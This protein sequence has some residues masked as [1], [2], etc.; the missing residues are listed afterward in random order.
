MDSL[1]NYAVVLI[2]HGSR[3]N[4]Y[5]EDIERMARS[6]GVE[7][8]VPVYLSYNEFNSPNWRDLLPKLLEKGITNVIFGLVFL[9]RG[10][11]VYHDIMGEMGAT[12]IGE[13][14]DV[15]YSGK[16]M[17]VFFTETLGRSPL[18][19]IALKYRLSRAIGTLPG[20]E[21]V[22]MDPE[23]IEDGSI[24][25]IL[26]RIDEKD[27]T[28]RKIIAKAVFAAG[29]LEVSKYMYIS[30]D[31][32][33]SGI[34]ALA[35]GTSI[36]ADVKMVSAG[37]RWKNVRCLIDDPYVIKSAKEKGVTRASEAIR[38]G[39]EEPSIVV[40]GNAPTALAE[41]LQMAKEGRDV[42]LIIATP[43]GFTNAVEVKEKLV[44]SGIPSIVLRGTMG[45]S[46]IA[47]SITNEIV[48]M[49]RNG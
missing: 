6:L 33:Q 41:A 7:M 25:K 39:L 49:S 32:I 2:G 18:V 48:R 38:K 43:P 40:V 29:N 23:A 42:P 30:D 19:K 16:R 37:I 15:H 31:A 36:L 11:H 35:S 24:S 14:E 5:N 21:D 3:R 26:E 45:G 10:N 27:D 34:E 28:K 1:S 47:A 9:G 13:W 4:T 22:L 8:K 46:G 44:R 20:I 17:K 12:K